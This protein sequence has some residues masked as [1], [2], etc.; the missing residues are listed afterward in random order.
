M[1]TLIETEMHH[2]ATS[3]MKNAGILPAIVQEFIR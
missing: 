3:L 2:T 1:L